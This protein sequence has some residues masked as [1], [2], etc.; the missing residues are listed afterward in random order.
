[1][2]L[3]AYRYLSN[4]A[5][6]VVFAACSVKDHHNLQKYSPLL[7]NNCVRQAIYIYVCMCIYIYIYVY[8]HMHMYRERERETYIY[9]YIYIYMCIERSV[10]QVAPPKDQHPLGY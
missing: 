7:K 3:L 2:A 9:I 8:I 1:M 6:F 4:T 5:S 10:R